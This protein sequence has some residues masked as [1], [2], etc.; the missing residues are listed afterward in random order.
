M[1]GLS[2]SHISWTIFLLLLEIVP[3]A[4]LERQDGII[5]LELWHPMVRA[6]DYA[7]KTENML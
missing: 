2:S 5:P 3:E 1:S 7:S 6:N 4:C